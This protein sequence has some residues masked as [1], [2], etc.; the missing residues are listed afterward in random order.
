MQIVYTPLALFPVLTQL[1]LGIDFLDESYLNDSS[2]DLILDSDDDSVV[3]LSDIK[4]VIDESEIPA[5]ALFDEARFDYE[6]RL[7]KEAKSQFEVLIL[8][9]LKD[10]ELRDAFQAHCA[11]HGVDVAYYLKKNRKTILT[12]APAPPK[13]E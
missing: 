11:K 2:G 12:L 13:L 1:L 10:K 5:Y 4:E 8:P 6:E 3:D 9:I 7:L